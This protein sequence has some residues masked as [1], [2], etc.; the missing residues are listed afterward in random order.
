MLHAVL[1]QATCSLLPLLLLPR[2]LAVVAIE[3]VGEVDRQAEERGVPED[4]DP[5]ST[6][7]A[8]PLF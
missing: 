4:W 3:G 6:Q 1:R 5:W 7:L 8:A 2:V